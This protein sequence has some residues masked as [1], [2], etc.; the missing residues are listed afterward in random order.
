MGRR[1]AGGRE[2]PHS[3]TLISIRLEQRAAALPRVGTA[4]SYNASTPIDCDL[5][6]R[7]RH[8]HLPVVTPLR[9]PAWFRCLASYPER[10]WAH[11]LVFDLVH[12]ADIGFRGTRALYRDAP[13]FADISEEKAAITADLASEAALSLSSLREF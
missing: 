2:R 12:G 1:P 5:V 10:D 7:C 11:R 9:P 4:G 13:N 8:T 6:V 3:L